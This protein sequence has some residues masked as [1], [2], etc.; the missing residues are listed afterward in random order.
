MS[1]TVA[2]KR[3]AELKLVWKRKI[4]DLS[5]VCLA[6]AFFGLC[7]LRLTSFSEQQY[8]SSP[9]YGDHICDLCEYR[10]H[11]AHT[12]ADTVKRRL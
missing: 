5:D 7:A 4:L 1:E 10:S 3:E 9:S 2:D 11:V 8:S 6:Y 12:P